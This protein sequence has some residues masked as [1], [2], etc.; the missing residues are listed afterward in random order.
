MD[1]RDY[2]IPHEWNYENIFEYEND[3]IRD[4]MN[5]Q[6]LSAGVIP[7]EK[8]KEYVPISK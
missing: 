4:L 6:N 1:S 7:T 2:D 8:M 3:Q 5:P